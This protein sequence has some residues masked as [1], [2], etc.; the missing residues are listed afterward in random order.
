M[1]LNATVN[2]IFQLHSGGQFEKTGV[3]GEKLRPVVSH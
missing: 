3:P 1:V 2:I